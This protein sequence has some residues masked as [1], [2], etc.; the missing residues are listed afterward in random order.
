MPFNHD[1]QG[2]Q[3]SLLKA[4]GAGALS[5]YLRNL[6]LTLFSRATQVFVEEK[7]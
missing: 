6:R 3:P 1:D 4:S 5:A 7:R 2:M